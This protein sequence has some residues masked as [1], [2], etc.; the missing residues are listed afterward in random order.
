MG[1]AGGSL[2]GV[3]VGVKESEIPHWKEECDLKT[4]IQSKTKMQVKC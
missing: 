4:G 2:T 3:C 1:P